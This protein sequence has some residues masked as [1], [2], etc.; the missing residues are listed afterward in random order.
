MKEL[1]SLAVVVAIVVHS[2]IAHYPSC[3]P[4]LSFNPFLPYLVIVTSDDCHRRYHY[5]CSYHYRR[6][7]LDRSSSLSRLVCR[8]L[9]FFAIASH[10]SSFSYFLSTLRFFNNLQRGNGYANFLIS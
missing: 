2:S 5:R 7:L 6:S 8:C 4:S 3:S 10:S 9:L 1:L